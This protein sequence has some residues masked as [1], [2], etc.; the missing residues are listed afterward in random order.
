MK[1]F[2]E[3]SFDFKVIDKNIY[4]PD[5]NFFENSLASL[6]WMQQVPVFINK[7][8]RK[9]SV[10]TISIFDL[11][12][13]PTNPSWNIIQCRHLISAL[14]ARAATGSPIAIRFLCMNARMVSR[15][16]VALIRNLRWSLMCLAY[17]LTC[18]PWV[19]VQPDTGRRTVDWC[20]NW[21]SVL[22]CTVWDCP[23]GLD[24]MVDSSV[25]FDD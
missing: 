9:C 14:N 18:Y 19:L 21:M 13:H 15:L 11:L 20:R 4:D 8:W 5:D 22:Y 2:C 25:V 16:Y 1:Y 6:F 12:Y 24:T 23:W 7:S 17:F 3:I 10:S